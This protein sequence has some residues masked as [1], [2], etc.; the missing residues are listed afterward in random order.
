MSQLDFRILYTSLHHR[1][2]LSV[3]TYMVVYLLFREACY[4]KATSEV[5]A[6]ACG[7]PKASYPGL[8]RGRKSYLGWVCACENLR[9]SRITNRTSK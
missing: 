9:V 5:H 7:S 6:Y 1:G 8:W 4:R 3:N 2:P